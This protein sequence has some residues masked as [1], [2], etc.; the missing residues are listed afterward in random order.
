MNLVNLVLGAVACLGLTAA[1]SAQRQHVN[2]LIG[3]P[4]DVSNW[5]H[6]AAPDG[7]PF[8]RST[9]NPADIAQRDMVAQL[10]KTLFWDEQ[11]S[12]DNTV[13]CGTCHES[14][15]GGVDGRQ[16]A[17]AANGNFG[18]FGVIP[19]AV[20][21]F[22]TVDY[23]F[24]ANPSPQ[25]ARSVTEVT[26]PTMIG[27]YV[28]ER[29]F[30]DMRAGPDFDDGFG[31]QLPLFDDWA[32]LEDLAVGPPLSDVEMG[33]EGLD[34]SSGFLQSK[35]NDSFPLAMVDPSTIPPDI[36]WITSMGAPY[37]KIFDIVFNG[38]SNP[39]LNSGGGV[40][41]ERFA[42]ALA[43]YHRMLIPDQAPI[44]IG[45]MTRQQQRGFAIMDR[46]GCFR[47][48]SATGN[49]QLAGPGGP[50]VD[51][52]DNA[53][54]DGQSH[55]INIAPV[56]RKTPTLRNLGLHT[57]WT[58]TGHGGDGSTRVFVASQS[59]LIR[60]YEAEPPPLGTGPLSPADRA[61]LA[62]FLFNALTDPRVAAEQ[63]PFD[64]PQLYSEVHGFEA[65]EYGFG[66]P[67]PGGF[68]TP[69]II[70]NSPPQILPN[71]GPSW[72]KVG[73]GDAP[74]NAAAFLMIGAAPI[75]STPPVFVDLI[76]AILPANPTN[77]Q[78]IG[79][80]QQPVT[81]NP[82]MLGIPFYAQWMVLDGR[83]GTSYSDAAEF[84][85]FHW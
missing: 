72:F 23:G 66:T 40:T 61:A 21:Q 54:S 58:S 69:E 22:G 46:A 19:Q 3:E 24:L 80:Y 31:N 83:Y 64:R 74:P 43:N 85:P 50:L 28:F 9:A 32:A 26:P 45:R 73:V 68:L 76:V 35:L 48:H 36:Q 17:V 15:F 33:H 12:V 65:N 25:I 78:G 49:P 52:F 55:S 56:R 13:S 42:A 44:D 59:D 14:K 5:P 67:A 37:S 75:F 39:A 81:L 79:T 63:F 70:A 38:H 84:F 34:W 62:D 60:F 18:A 41:R 4:P 51:P 27:A 16:G 10:G 30:W 8:V 1:A 71:G 6:P 53:F 20:S 57:K 2:G 7:N 82:G 77:A 29:L 47:C 11:V